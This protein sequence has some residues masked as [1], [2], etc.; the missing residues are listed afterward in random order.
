VRADGVER[1][2]RAFVLRIGAKR[3]RARAVNPATVMETYLTG[4]L[5]TLHKSGHISQV[6]LVYDD[7]YRDPEEGGDGGEGVGGGDEGGEGVDLDEKPATLLLEPTPFELDED[8]LPL[9]HAFPPRPTVR[10]GVRH[11]VLPDGLSEPMERVVQRRY[12]KVWEMTLMGRSAYEVAAADALLAVLTPSRDDKRIDT[13][14]EEVVGED[15]PAWSAWNVGH[16]GSAAE[17]GERGEGGPSGQGARDDSSG[18]PSGARSV[19]PTYIETKDPPPAAFAAAPAAVLDP[20]D[21]SAAMNA[22]RA[23][24]PFAL[25]LTSIASTS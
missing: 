19:G 16:G 18:R 11:N 14:D 2:D 5:T 17:D 20:V 1:D 24:A 12:D 8:G 9:L 22:P 21:R 15:D 10:S 4:D 7:Y 25:V 6:L 3:Y 23:E 13:M